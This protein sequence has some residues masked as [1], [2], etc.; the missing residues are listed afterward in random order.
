MAGFPILEPSKQAARSG[1]GLSLFL[2]LPPGE[3]RGEG[4]PAK[5]QISRG[6]SPPISPHPN[7]LPEGE[8]I[9]TGPSAT[10]QNED[11]S[12]RFMSLIEVIPAPSPL[13]PSVAPP[14]HHPIQPAATPDRLQEFFEQQASARPTAIA[15]EHDGQRLTYAEL[16]ARANQLAHL[17]IH[18]GVGTGDA[19]GIL[20]DRSAQTYVALLAVLKCGAAFVPIDPSF[21]TERV[22][23]IAEDAG[24]ALLLTFARRAAG[25]AAMSCPI[26]E[27]DSAASEICSYPARAR[28]RRLRRLGLLRHLYLRHHR[29]PEGRGRHPFQHLQFPLRACGPIYGYRADDRVYQGMTIAFDFSIEEIWPTLMAGATIVAGPN[30]HRRLGPGLAEFL[31]EQNVT[32]M[33]CVP[34]LLA[35]LDRDVPSL[36]LLLVGGEACPR[37][38]VAALEPARPARC[39]TPTA[40]P[41]PPSL[42]RGPN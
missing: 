34:T 39:S 22:K 25:L 10:E 11:G 42:R 13:R 18:R 14:W 35:T 38:L 29:P 9:R 4:K 20:L 41:K 37:D 6:T 27:L 19:V 23:F 1:W 15:V 26:V 16:E 2:P 3:G 36:R 30:D 33:C 24:I 31:I 40:R 12:I 21:P 8:G 28:C 17:L 7:P 32:V 5:T